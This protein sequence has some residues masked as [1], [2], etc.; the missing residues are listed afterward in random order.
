MSSKMQPEVINRLR[1]YP[2]QQANAQ[3]CVFNGVLGT[4]DLSYITF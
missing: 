3:A 1:L 4:F 2:A